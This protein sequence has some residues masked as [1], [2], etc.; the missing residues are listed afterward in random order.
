MGL[1]MQFGFQDNAEIVG[2]PE[3]G[4]QI[5]QFICYLRVIELSRSLVLKTSFRNQNTS[6]VKC[7]EKLC[8]VFKIP[9]Q[10]IL[11]L[12]PKNI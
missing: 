5:F 10:F 11:Y 6:N 4:R 9:V 12:K 2:H 7:T 3:S 8:L 1:K